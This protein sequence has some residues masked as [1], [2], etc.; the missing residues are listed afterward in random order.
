MP[1]KTDINKPYIDNIEGYDRDRYLLNVSL[2]DRLDLG[3]NSLPGAQQVSTAI[4]HT[5]QISE[6]QEHLSQIRL[7]EEMGNISQ[8]IADDNISLIPQVDGIVDSRNSPD[9][10]PVSVD[11]MESP[12]KHTNTQKQ[13]Q[14]T[15][16]DT[17]DN[18]T[19]D[20][21]SYESDQV[22]KSNRKNNNTVKKKGRMAKIYTMNIER[23][24][25]LKQR[26]EN[27]LQKAKG[28]RLAEEYFLTA[29]KASCK[30]YKALKS[31]QKKKKNDNGSIDDESTNITMI[32]NDINNLE[33]V[34][35]NDATAIMNAKNVDI[36]PV[37]T[38]NVNTADIENG[39]ADS[40]T[41][42][43]KNITMSDHNDDNSVISN[44]DSP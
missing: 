28:K 42:K 44:N 4:K 12:A 3:Q 2:S 1:L 5:D 34:T 30:S 33:I 6:F 23:K 31:E 21:I 7:A 41:D 29:L 17:S 27:T 36:E 32:A 18:D 15:N 37:D 13:R 39:N 43:S 9:R 20:R 25:L 14:K 10:T 26:R 16:E 40:N 8:S 24:K 11:L 38:D 19:D 22:T 35:N